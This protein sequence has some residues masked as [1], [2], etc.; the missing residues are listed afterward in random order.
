MEKHLNSERKF[1]SELQ[2]RTVWILYN[3]AIIYF[4]VFTEFL[5]NWNVEHIKKMCRVH[6]VLATAETLMFSESFF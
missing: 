3:W 4:Y 1:I 2:Q 5:L 6:S